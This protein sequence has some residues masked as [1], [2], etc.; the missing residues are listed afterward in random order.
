M[1]SLQG[2]FSQQLLVSFLFVEED[3]ESL[4]CIFV[5]P[6]VLLFDPFAPTP[7][8]L[9]LLM[10]FH[11]TDQ[12]SVALSEI[13]S[14]L[15]PVDLSTKP[16]INPH[17][18]LLVHAVVPSIFLFMVKPYPVAVPDP[19]LEVALIDASVSP[20]VLSIALGHSVNV[21]THVL[22]P[23]GEGFNSVA[24]LEPVGKGAFVLVLSLVGAVA[25]R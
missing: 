6:G 25:M 14:K 24:E 3:V 22:V 13:L 12:L 19:M 10:T 17:S 2:L 15:A 20:G 4:G 11:N 18:F 5:N 1:S 21:L 7:P 8:K 23:V 16:G 9:E